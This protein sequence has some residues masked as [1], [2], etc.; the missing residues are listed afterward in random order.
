V[1][2]DALRHGVGGNAFLNCLGLT[3]VSIPNSVT[4][5]ESSTFYGCRSLTGVT[6]PD[7]VVRIVHYAFAA[8]DS[9]K[10]VYFTGPAPTIGAYVFEYVTATAYYP[11]GDST[12]T[13][14]KLKDHGGK[15]T[16]VAA[17]KPT[18]TA[19]PKS[20]TVAE[21]G[22]A[23]FT[24]EAS[25]SNLSYQ[26]YCRSSST[27]SWVKC[28]AASAKTATHTP[29]ALPK[30]SGYRYKCVVTNGAGS[31]TSNIVTLTVK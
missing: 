20:C 28:Q 22:S 3:S 23:S 31:A 19:Q 8:C 18:I 25:G 2:G 10:T 6:I 21:G 24:V 30:Y 15:I 26:W 1:H 11:A 16:W 12:W 27:G 14:D 5:I 4:V 7:S 29:A 13:A 17:S 9:L